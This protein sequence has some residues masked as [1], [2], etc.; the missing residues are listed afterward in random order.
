MEDS[1]LYEGQ[2][3]NKS[4]VQ[5]EFF[6]FLYLGV[7]VSDDKAKACILFLIFTAISKN[8]YPDVLLWLH[9]HQ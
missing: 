5:E 2:V 4:V 6:R 8:L 1:A 3:R 9:L 7:I